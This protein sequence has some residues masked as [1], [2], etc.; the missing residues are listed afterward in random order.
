MSVII[1]DMGNLA[2]M[3]DYREMFCADAVTPATQKTDW[4]CGIN[5][6]CTLAL[7]NC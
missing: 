5:G 3:D 7:N 1:L 2:Y 4:K 6:V